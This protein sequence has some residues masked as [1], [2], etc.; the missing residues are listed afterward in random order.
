MDLV[1]LESLVIVDDGLE[2]RGYTPEMDIDIDG[3]ELPEVEKLIS[4]LVD[5]IWT[6]RQLKA[7]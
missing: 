7:A 1:A 2:L 5:G 3:T 4:T 6:S